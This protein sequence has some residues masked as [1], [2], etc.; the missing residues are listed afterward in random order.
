M[1]NPLVLLVFATV[2]AVAGN[3]DAQLDDWHFG[4]RLLYVEASTT[5]G[6]LGDTGARIDFDSGF[7]AEFDATLR[8]SRVFSAEFSIGI[9]GHELTVAGTECCGDIDGG[10]AFVVP[11]TA[12][13]QYHW[14]VYGNWDPYVGIGLTWAVPIYSI[15]S[16]ME[17]SGI[18]RLELK[19]GGGFA[20]QIGTNYQMDN[21]WYANVDLRYLGYS[22][23]AETTTSDGDLP[24]VDL[25]TKP[26][27][28]GVG[29]GYRF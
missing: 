19:G 13:A 27:V 14:P 29:I 9:S 2:V 18:E 11:L 17:E 16:D 25:D 1:R 3:A 8:V 10:N 4:G 15:S 23:E 20:A 24:T 22:L 5:S 28:I 12:L 26:W 6:E 21:R 7:G